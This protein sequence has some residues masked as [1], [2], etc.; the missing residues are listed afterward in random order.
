M[1]LESGNWDSS[2]TDLEL[3]DILP[4]SVTRSYRQGDPELRAFGYSESDNL[5]M[6]VSPDTSGNYDLQTP[7]GA[8]V[9]FAPSGTSYIYDATGSTSYEGA[10][11]DEIADNDL[12]SPS[13]DG[14]QYDFGTFHPSADGDH[15]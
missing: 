2:H 14:T 8:D 5:D 7:D 4:I 6:F 1:D 11:L 9:T 12:S 3:P 13:K 10:T 15:R